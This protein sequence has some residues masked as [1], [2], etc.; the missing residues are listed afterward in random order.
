MPSHP[1]FD[2]PFW[3]AV[4][5]GLFSLSSLGCF[6]LAAIVQAEAP[7]PAAVMS[8]DDCPPPRDLL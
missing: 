8:T 7:A 2:A 6:G 3:V 4:L 1:R 5:V